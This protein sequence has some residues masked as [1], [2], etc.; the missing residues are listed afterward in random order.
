MLHIRSLFHMSF[1]ENTHTVLLSIRLRL[2]LMNHSI[3]ICPA[4][5]DAVEEFSKEILPNYNSTA[6]HA[7][8]DISF[9]NF[10]L[11]F[12]VV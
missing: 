12:P 2:R 11:N 8:F 7:N 5:V 4:L 1:D 6:T 9:Y 10:N 3:W